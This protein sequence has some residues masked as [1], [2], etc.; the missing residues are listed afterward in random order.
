MYYYYI[1]VSV[2]AYLVGSIPFAYIIVKLF[3]KQDIRQLGSGNVGAINVYESTGSKLYG[4]IVLILDFLKAFIFIYLI[5]KYTDDSLFIRLSAAF[6]VLGHNYSI[7][8]ALS[9]GRGLATAA[10]AFAFLNPFGIVIWLIMYYTGKLIISKNVHIAIAIGLIGAN[11][12]LWASPTELLKLFENYKFADIN[13]F[14][15]LYMLISIFILSKLIKPIQEQ[16]G[17]AE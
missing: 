10:G 17:K 5:N 14:R 4:I 12:M 8:L 13:E 16:L 9:G 3:A 6:L 1:I 2:I 11:I 15:T 7:F